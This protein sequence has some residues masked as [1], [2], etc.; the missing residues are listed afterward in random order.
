MCRAH[1]DYRRPDEYVDP[2]PILTDIGRAVAQVN[3]VLFNYTTPLRLAG[4]ARVAYTTEDDLFSAE[5][6]A[7]ANAYGND[8]LV[9]PMISLRPSDPLRFSF[10]AEVLFGRESTPLGAL[11]HYSGAFAEARYVF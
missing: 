7:L 3:A 6:F 5:L 9:R 2:N 8:G 1:V 10:G 4:T 11:R